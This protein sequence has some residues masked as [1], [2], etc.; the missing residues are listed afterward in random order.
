M[1]SDLKYAVRSLLKRP[2]F[3]L[4][5]IITLALGMGSATAIFSVL[6][7]VLLRPLPYPQQERIVELSEL[8]EKGRA[9]R[10]AEPNYDDLRARSRSFQAL[11]KYSAWPQAVAGGR[12]AVRTKVCA[13]SADF[14]RVLGVTPYVGRLLP[15][16]ANGKP[17]Q[18]AVVSYGFWKR[19]LGSERNLETLALRIDNR[20]F[21]VVG[22]LPPETEFPPETDVWFPSELSPPAESRTAHNWRAAGRLRD[23]VTIG[24]ARAEI[25]AIGQQLKREHGSQTDAVSF[26]AAPLRE[27]MVKDVRGILFVL[28]GAVGLL[29][30]IACS[31]VGNL[32]LVRVS[33]RRK[34]IALRAALGASR[35]RLAAQFIIESLLLT[36]VAGAAGVLLA[37]WGVDLIVGLYHGN[38]PHIGSVGVDRNVLLFTLGVAVLVGLVLGLVPVLH[39][40][41]RQL[42]NDLQD[43]GRGQ[44]TSRANLRIR[45]GLIVGQVALTLILL[46]GGLIGVFFII[47]LR[48]PLCVDAKLPWP[49]SVASAQIV[50]AGAEGSDAPKY[51]FG[52]MGLGALI[53]ILKSDRGES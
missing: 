27:R 5:A 24:A 16:G 37:F 4:V 43:A 33:A 28:C 22:V 3:T 23:A 46:V 31:N 13:A 50:R 2:G 11:A 8:N 26:G 47:V 20:S 21:A 44:S 29:L 18:V 34:E 12:E 39:A 6:N 36:L 10:F 15:A 19:L 53:Q 35:G 7:A 45:N 9:M 25:A 52:A 1:T 40:S 42:Q 48:R 38:L 41:T 17:E 32:L 30:L 49:E 14:F 51:I